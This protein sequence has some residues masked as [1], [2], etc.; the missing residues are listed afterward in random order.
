MLDLT[1]MSG[2]LQGVALVYVLL[3]LIALTFAGVKPKHVGAKLA[4]MAL[5]LLILVG[6]VAYV[7]WDRYER[8]SKARALYEAAEAMFR[9]R[10]KTAGVKVYRTD[11]DVEGIFLMKLRPQGINYGQQFALTDPYGD[12]FDGD[13]Y[14]MSFLRGS[15]PASN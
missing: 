13:G 3:V 5:V 4:G 9:E 15:E 8:T 1:G 2:L 14:I 10:C 11:H 7:V 6:P 12:D